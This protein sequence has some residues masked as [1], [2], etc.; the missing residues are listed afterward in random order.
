[1][2]NS[3]VAALLFFCCLSASANGRADDNAQIRSVIE[4]FRTAIINKDRE[5]FLGLFL[6]EDVTWQAVMS[7]ARLEQAKQ[8]DP[9]ARKAAFDRAQSPAN[10][11]D[12]IAKDLK[13]NEETFS[14][15]LIDSDGDTASV[16]FDFSYMRDGRITNVGREYWLL[17]RTEMGW[18]IAAVTYSRNFPTKSQ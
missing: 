17:A 14:N 9:A 5:K 18:K 7:D 1:M 10:F 15:I 12:G 2:R 16:A 8:K 11:I 6:H 4:D 3:I 13:T